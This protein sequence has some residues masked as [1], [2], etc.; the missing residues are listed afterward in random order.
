MKPFWIVVSEA[1]GPANWP[2]RHPT[3]DSAIAESVRLARSNGGAFYV[4]EAQMVT[5]KR[6]I[7]TRRIAD[8]QEIPF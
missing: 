3:Q 2:L 1:R 4:M 8:D 6:D 5:E 7:V